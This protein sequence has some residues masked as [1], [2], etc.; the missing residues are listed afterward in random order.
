[1]SS[2]IVE[3]PAN[4][5]PMRRLFP[6]DPVQTC[7]V[8]RVVESFAD[9]W[10]A[11]SQSPAPRGADGRDSCDR[12]LLI[13]N[14]AST[15]DGR[16]SVGGRSGAIGNRADRGLFHGL[17]AIV[18]AVMVGAGTARIE[19]Y[20]RMIRES[21]RRRRRSE[22]GLEPEPTTCIV[23]RSVA[24]TPAL[25]PVL[26]E[27]EA[28]VTILTQSQASLPPEGVEAQIHYIRAAKAGA[29]DLRAGLGELRDRFGVRTLL[30]EGGPHLNAALL[31]AGLVDELLLCVGP[32]LAGGQSSESSLR[33]LA[34]PELEPPL[35]LELLDAFENESN[36]F[37][38][39]GVRVPVAGSAGSMG[40]AGT[41][42]ST[43]SEP[44]GA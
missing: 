2:A 16:A 33:I 43:G 24:L 35:E 25:V 12:P 26:G 29:L 36:L 4:T 6:G 31:G 41:L 11:A 30:C 40:A 37:L 7:T 22:S 20:G 19:H 8:E 14:M 39:Y 9:A 38:R 28:R 1:M 15:V 5:L 3:Q 17:R 44:A 18:D 27:P 23:S 34:G 21:D 10:R 42:G 32:K 13:L